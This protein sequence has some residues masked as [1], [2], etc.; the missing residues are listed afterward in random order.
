MTQSQHTQHMLCGLPTICAQ[1]WQWLTEPQQPSISCSEGRPV[2]HV[3]FKANAI[4][5]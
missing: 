5:K 2:F 4:V 1:W 3:F